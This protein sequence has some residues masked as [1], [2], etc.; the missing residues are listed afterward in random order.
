VAAEEHSPTTTE[1]LLIN[2]SLIKGSL[3]LQVRKNQL[4]ERFHGGLLGYLGADRVTARSLMTLTAI[5]IVEN[6]LYL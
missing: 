4:M 5:K 6:H 1:E 2:D 3:Y